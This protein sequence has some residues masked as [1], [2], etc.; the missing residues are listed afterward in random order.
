M[1]KNVSE[2]YIGFF[3]FFSLWEEMK[4]QREFFYILVTFKICVCNK[5]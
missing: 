5:D 3:F 1:N 4:I 2:K